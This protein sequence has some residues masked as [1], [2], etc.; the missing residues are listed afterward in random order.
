VNDVGLEAS[1]D[2]SNACRPSKERLKKIDLS[3]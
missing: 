1:G 2:L 3:F